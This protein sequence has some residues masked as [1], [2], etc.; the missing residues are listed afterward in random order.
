MIT[1]NKPL[2]PSRP[3]ELPDLALAQEGIERMREGRPDVTTAH[4]KAIVETAQI[5]LDQLAQFDVRW[6]ADMR[7]INRWKAGDALDARTRAVLIEAADELIMAADHHD[8]IA[9]GNGA[10]YRGFATV[11]RQ[12]LE[13]SRPGA[14]PLIWP[15]HS[16]LVVWLMTLIES[17]PGVPNITAIMAQQEALASAARGG[18]IMPASVALH[19]R[20]K[21]TIDQL[22]GFLRRAEMRV[23][24]AEEG[25]RAAMA[26]LAPERIEAVLIEALGNELGDSYDCTRVWEA[27][28]I[29]TM[30]QDD[31]EP[32][33]DRLDEIV[34]ALVA[35]IAG[36]PAQSAETV[37]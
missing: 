19:A 16:D 22:I 18:V 3:S 24:A 8:R 12:H 9:N 34:A 10:R 1:D 37:Q 21:V 36:R 11:I 26:Q 15:D 14:R 30:A 23:L 31:F 29:G 17:P 35:A 5:G 2:A 32:V 33:G 28:A 4:I 6:A 25:L 27:W 13:D 7:A 20:A